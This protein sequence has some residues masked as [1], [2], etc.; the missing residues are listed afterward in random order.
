MT[1]P[2]AIFKGLTGALAGL[3]AA[4]QVFDLIVKS[5]F[6]AKE[7]IEAAHAINK[8]EEESVKESTEALNGIYDSWD[9]FAKH[10]DNVDAFFKEDFSPMFSTI[11]YKFC[12]RF[13]FGGQK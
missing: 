11:V 2:I 12:Q 10:D 13:I 9:A 6:T 3:S 7:V 8:G 5:A 4:P 1:N